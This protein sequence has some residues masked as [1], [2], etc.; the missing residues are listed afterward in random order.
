MY[1]FNNKID[2]FV[3]DN[4]NVDEEYESSPERQ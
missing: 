1:N 3:G 4:D 2:H